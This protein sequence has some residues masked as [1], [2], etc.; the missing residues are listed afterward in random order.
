ML[1][2]LE[3]VG[4]HKK[5][6]IHRGL[7]EITSDTGVEHVPIDDIHI[8]LCAGFGISYTH[9]FLV[10]LGERT[11]P[12]ILCNTHYF[13]TSIVLPFEA[14]GLQSKIQKAQHSISVP[15]QKRLW[16][17]L[18]K[19]K[20]RGHCYVLEECG[21]DTSL[22]KH[23]IDKVQSGDSTNIE[24]VAAST[25]W[26]LLFGIQ[27]R[28]DQQGEDIQNIMLNY[29]Y[30]VLRASVARAL[31]SSGLHYAFGIYHSNARNSMPLV[32]DLMEPYRCFAERV[33]LEALAKGYTSLTKESKKILNRVT[34]SEVTHEEGDSI[35]YEC[36]KRTCVSLARVYL[37][38]REDLVI[39][40]RPKKSIKII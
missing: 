15:K 27:F 3:I 14:H 13:P 24:G 6:S 16:Q 32:D 25:Y 28:R 2:T 4:M 11:I 9:N 30:T 23:Y 21:I 17:Q 39:Q 38:E 40:N 33:V 34:I 20:I 22:L 12:L 1:K 19:E 8:V 36:I 31:L 18:V 5:L 10:A 29:S 35:V 26:K 7:I 37:K